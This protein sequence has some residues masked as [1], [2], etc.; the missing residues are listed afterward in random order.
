MSI[1]RRLHR[2]LS[3]STS[4]TGIAGAAEFADPSVRR[5]VATASEGLPVVGLGDVGQPVTVDLDGR[6]SHVAVCCYGGDE[7]AWILRAV[8]SQALHHGAR[9]TIL[10]CT[11]ESQQWAWGL[12]RVELLSDVADVHA[13]LV[14]TPQSPHDRLGEP[15][16]PRHVIVVEDSHET[17]AD[18]AVWWRRRRPG[19]TTDVSPS[20]GALDRLIASGSNRRI[21]V[22]LAT[23]GGPTPSP[24]LPAASLI[25]SRAALD[26]LSPIL[27]RAPHPA[28]A[29]LAPGLAPVPRPDWRHAGRIHLAR[30]G[31]VIEARA[32][33]MTDDEARDWAQSAP[34]SP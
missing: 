27:V 30:D 3:S 19:R 7:A 32:L 5:L 6:D 4:R 29:A 33:Y 26:R 25:Q 31:H 15:R 21:N 2:R 24:Y 18:L 10:N 14:D 28:W 9:A 22:L 12:P 16:R 17:A 23:C 20:V 34:G 13:W 8:T 1:F 11:R